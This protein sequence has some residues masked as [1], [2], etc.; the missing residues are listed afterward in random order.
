MTKSQKETAVLSVLARLDE[1]PNTPDYDRVSIDLV[2]DGY[3]YHASRM[4]MP[5]SP[6]P[7]CE[8]DVEYQIQVSNLAFITKRRD[9]RAWSC[10]VYINRPRYWN[11]DRFKSIGNTD[12][13]VQFLTGF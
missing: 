1:L 2:I 12:Y 9:Y 3:T 11:C 7:V 6:R 13:G 10:F 5:D 4:F 8:L